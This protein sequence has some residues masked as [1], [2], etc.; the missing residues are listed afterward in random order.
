M[1]VSVIYWFLGGFNGQGVEWIQVHLPAPC[2]VTAITTQGRPAD[3]D[4]YVTSYNV[5]YS[6]DGVNFVDVGQVS[7]FFVV[8]KTF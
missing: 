1:T 5:R 3:Y 8:S 2:A 4:Q 7:D 6:N